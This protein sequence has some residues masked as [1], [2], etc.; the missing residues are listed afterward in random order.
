MNRATAAPVRLGLKENLARFSLLAGVN[1]LVGIVAFGV[2]KAGT[3][4]VAD[5]PS[6]GT[7]RKSVLVLSLAQHAAGTKPFESRR[8][9][10]NISH[11]DIE[12]HPVL[13]HLIL[14]H[15][16]QQQLGI[17]R[18]RTGDRHCHRGPSDSNNWVPIRTARWM[19]TAREVLRT[20]SG[21]D[22]RPRGDVCNKAP[23]A[24]TLVTTVESPTR[25]TVPGTGFDLPGR[26]GLSICRIPATVASCGIPATSAWSERPEPVEQ[27]AATISNPRRVVKATRF[28]T[29]ELLHRGSRPPAVPWTPW[30]ASGRPEVRRADPLRRSYPPQPRC[31]CPATVAARGPF[32]KSSN[33]T[34]NARDQF[35]H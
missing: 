27:L 7:G 35:G 32:S 34:G 26:G 15:P 21:H 1:V 6:D 28:S 30:P 13:D 5:T 9:R 19:R 20:M 14:R 3:N 10:V 33:G 24:P 2:V 11:P 23:S 29:Y 22:V 4:F 25:V 31:R 16:L 17:S 12:M 8:L 18:H